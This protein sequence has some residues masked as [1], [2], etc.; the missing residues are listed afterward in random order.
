M[1][2]MKKGKAMRSAGILVGSGKMSRNELKKRLN[3]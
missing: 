3:M 1:K 2:K